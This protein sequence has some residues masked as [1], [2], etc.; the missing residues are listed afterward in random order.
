MHAN[1]GNMASTGTRSG[2]LS[3]TTLMNVV[4]LS[5]TVPAKI[6]YTVTA[7]GEGGNRLRVRCGNFIHLIWAKVHDFELDPGESGTRSFEVNSDMTGTE[8]GKHDIRFRLSRKA[9]TK[10]IDWEVTWKIT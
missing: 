6:E 2:T 3:G 5:I 10:A 4:N 1:G 9:L 8:D 7:R